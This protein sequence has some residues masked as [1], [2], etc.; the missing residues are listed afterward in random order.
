MAGSLAHS[1]R[2]AAIGRLLDALVE[3]LR[4]AAG[5]DASARPS[6]EE[7]A[8]LVGAVDRATLAATPRER[9]RVPVCRLW[10]AALRAARGPLVAPLTTLG[11]SLSWTQN[12]NY[13]RRPPDAAFLDN[14]GYAVIAG[15]LEGPPAL[16]SDPHVAL[17]VLLLGPRTHYPLHAHPSVE[18]Y[19]TLTAD[20]EWWREDGPWRDEPAGALIHHASGVPHATRAGDT[21]LLAVYVWR[22]SLATY[23]RLRP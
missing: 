8:R 16:V 18:V 9:Q 7:F 12:P 17:G 13:R 20:A 6:L 19:V 21:P 22:G 11:E 10:E 15:P 4:A 1:E 3:C 2:A 5:A 23:A 14:Y